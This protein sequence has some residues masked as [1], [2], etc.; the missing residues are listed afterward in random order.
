MRERAFWRQRKVSLCCGSHDSLLDVT[1]VLVYI[2]VTTPS[3]VSY[4]YMAQ[5]L[6]TEYY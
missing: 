4:S 1:G 3:M 2:E 6:R 5:S